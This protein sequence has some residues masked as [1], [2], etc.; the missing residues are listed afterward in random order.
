MSEEIASR[1][2]ALHISVS[3]PP[4]NSVPMNGNTPEFGQSDRRTKWIQHGNMNRS[5][6]KRRSKKGQSLRGQG[7]VRFQDS[8][9]GRS[10]TN[11]SGFHENMNTGF[12]GDY[13]DPEDSG[14]L[15]SA[16]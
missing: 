9:Y 16:Y 13:R 3:D 12:S 10:K 5:F 6:R 7:S 15:S 8:L 4:L 11:D 14:G 1:R 2:N